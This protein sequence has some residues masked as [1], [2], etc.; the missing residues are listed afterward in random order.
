MKSLTYLVAATSALISLASAQD[1]NVTS[2]LSV[3]AT[4]VAASVS[5]APTL[6]TGETLQLTDSVL[7][8]VISNINNDTIS[9]LFTFDSNSTNSTVSKRD[10]HRCKL[11]PGDIFWPVNLIWEIFDI[12]LGGALIK[13]TPLAASCYTAWPEYNAD[14][15]ATVTANWL[16]SQLQ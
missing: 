14:T 4:Q 16:L 3:A 12:L 15:C 2:S 10:A 7:A 9:S 6:F 8:N 1:A 13:A 5:A 11:M